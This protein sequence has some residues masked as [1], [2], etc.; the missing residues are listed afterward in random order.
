MAAAIT[1]GA[2]D[3]SRC[4]AR[5]CPCL[6]RRNRFDQKKTLVVPHAVVLPSH[7]LD[8]SIADVNRIK[9]H[10]AFVPQTRLTLGFPIKV[11]WFSRRADRQKFLSN[12]LSYPEKNYCQAPRVGQLG[13]LVF[14]NPGFPGVKPRRPVLSA[15]RKSVERDGTK[16]TVPSPREPTNR[17]LKNQ[18][19]TGRSSARCQAATNYR[20]Y[21]KPCL[22]SPA[23]RK[24][25]FLSKRFV[26]QRPP[27]CL[28]E[29]I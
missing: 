28:L 10:I 18:L 22:I 24:K 3:C 9:C 1:I 7:P 12:I 14:T 19:T 17:R 21:S 2:A 4:E 5:L 27:T 6:F 8:H 11:F 15:H 29:A 20:R 13:L 23:P 16:G 25:P 26:L